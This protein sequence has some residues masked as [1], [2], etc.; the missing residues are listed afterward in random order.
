M[1]V[2]PARLGAELGQLWIRVFVGLV[3]PFAALKAVLVLYF[4]TGGRSFE[5]SWK[6][7]LKSLMYYGSDI[8]GAALM[9][10]LV[11]AL[12]L[13]PLALGRLRVAQV[14]AGVLA[15]LL[16][17]FE[18]ASTI[19]QIYM[20]GPLTLQ[21]FQAVILAEDSAGVS[22]AAMASSLLDMLNPGSVALL[23]LPPVLALWG[24][25]GPGRQLARWKGWGPRVLWGL[26]GAEVILTVVFVPL[27]VSGEIGLRIYSDGLEDSPS[28]KLLASLGSPLVERLSPSVVLEDPFRVDLGA[29]HE[30]RPEAEKPP[31]AEAR[32]ARTNVVFVMLESVGE[33]YQ[34]GAEPFMPF[35]KALGT[36]S[37]EGTGGAWFK[38]HYSTFSLTTAAWFSMLC[39]ELPYPSF[40]PV[41]RLN[42]SIPCRCLSETLAEEGYRTILASSHPATWDQRTG[43]LKYRAFERSFDSLSNPRRPQAFTNKWGIDDAATVDEALSLLAQDDGRP[44]FLFLMLISGHHPFIASREQA[45]HPAPDRL[46]E[47]QRALAHG[48]RQLRRFHD[49]LVRLGLDDKTLIV[50]VSDHGEA[51]GPQAGR[52][53][54]ESVV[55]VPLVISG[56]QLE[57][58]VLD[59]DL[60]TS[61]TDIPP[62]I[63]GLLGIPVPC[64]MKGRNLVKDGLPQ[65]AF[66]GGRPPKAQLGLLD[67]PWKFV[68]E[69]RRSGY[70]FNVMDDPDQHTDL[71]E[72]QP[73]LAAELE[74]RLRYVIGH[75]EN[76]IP[77]YGAILRASG[78]KP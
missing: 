76:L 38:R 17:S 49:G 34:E 12:V 28:T 26:L 54:L 19:S 71:A 52:N 20:G 59:S 18:G 13:I 37:G 53:V 68:L 72:A 2:G 64:S 75:A 66:F 30:I 65:V 45:E 67:G 25:H 74:Q 11:L 51:H 22:Q 62:T 24:F 23:L 8:L 61:H 36:E 77:N 10:L 46:T 40:K 15:G 70:L 9:A 29:R 5:L 48:D 42:P 55:R 73:E 69:D 47:Y 27:M 33:V 14:L 35:L 50:V 63:L 7:G 16:A 32:P 78:C 58:L 4:A 31:L 39:S 6:L 56:P 1:T 43:F 3:L 60:V 44:F 57:G 21:A 41:T